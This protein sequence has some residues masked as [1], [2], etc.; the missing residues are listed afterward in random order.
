MA[1]L[2]PYVRQQIW[3]DPIPAPKEHA[4]TVNYTVQWLGHINAP[5]AESEIFHL[6]DASLNEQ[7]YF[8]AIKNL[9][10]IA[11]WPP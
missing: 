8:R 3:R 5:K 7:R 2:I 11:A 9:L 1:G 10:A 4:D 6:V